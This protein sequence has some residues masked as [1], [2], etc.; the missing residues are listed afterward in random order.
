MGG[1]AFGWHL[2]GIQ[3]PMGKRTFVGTEAETEAVAPYV[4]QIESFEAKLRGRGG[5]AAS[6]GG[7][8]EGG[9]ADK[10]KK[11]WEKK[12]KVEKKED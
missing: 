8:E 10:G 9:S 7:E 4:T 6:S 12:K 1:V 2:A 11:T 5:P 3:V